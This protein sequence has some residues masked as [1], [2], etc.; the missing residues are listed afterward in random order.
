M[1]VV[2]QGWLADVTSLSEGLGVG[3]WSTSIGVVGGRYLGSGKSLDHILRGSPSLNL[4]IDAI[5]SNIV[6]VLA[7]LVV[8]LMLMLLLVERS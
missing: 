7:V 4:P 6:V 5:R 2:S 1:D 8:L 3:L